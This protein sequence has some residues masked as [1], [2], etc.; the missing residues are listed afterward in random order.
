MTNLSLLL[1]LPTYPEAEGYTYDQILPGF[2]LKSFT[3]SQS[4]EHTGDGN[5]C[6]RIIMNYET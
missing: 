3:G 6:R 5:I 4:L 2:T 1:G